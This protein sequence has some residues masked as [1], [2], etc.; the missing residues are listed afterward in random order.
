VGAELKENP[1]L[2]V[3]VAEGVL[4]LRLLWLGKGFVDGLTGVCAFTPRKDDAELV[5]DAEGVADARGEDGREKGAN[6]GL[7]TGEDGHAE[8]VVVTVTV[9]SIRTVLMPS[10]PVEVKAEVP[11]DTFAGAGAGG[12]VGMAPKMELDAGD[13]VGASGKAKGTV[14]EGTIPPKL[15]VLAVDVEPNWR[16]FS[17]MMGGGAAGALRWT[18]GGIPDGCG[19]AA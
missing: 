16:L 11:F 18:T 10:G 3:V 7:K 8:A 13:V 19:A 14:L 9:A 5:E 4:R 1:A 6:A 2:E 15:K 12:E 17:L